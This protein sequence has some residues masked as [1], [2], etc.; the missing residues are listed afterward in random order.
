MEKGVIK[1]TRLMCGQD[2][3][4]ECKA[5]TGLAIFIIFNSLNG[6][7]PK[8]SFNGTQVQMTL[9]LK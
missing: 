6:T 5:V 2:F 3:T 8:G 7:S 9:V 4:G 1:V